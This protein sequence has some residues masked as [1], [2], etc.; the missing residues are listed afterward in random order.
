MTFRVTAAEDHQSTTWHAVLIAS[1]HPGFGKTRT[2]TTHGLPSQPPC[3]AQLSTASAT[4]LPRLLYQTTLSLSQMSD[5]MRQDE[6]LLPPGRGTSDWGAESGQGDSP[7]GQHICVLGLQLP[8][9]LGK[10]LNAAVYCWYRGIEDF[11]GVLLHLLGLLS[12][13]CSSWSAH[14]TIEL[15]LADNGYHVLVVFA[16]EAI[17]LCAAAVADFWICSTVAIVRVEEI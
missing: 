1:K 17:R 15:A 9:V 8:R 3:G 2:T 7:Y 12:S 11:C 4:A 16:S 13:H 6:T 5:D 10:C 14:H